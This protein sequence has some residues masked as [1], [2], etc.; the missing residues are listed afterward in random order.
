VPR[1]F[2]PGEAGSPLESLEMHTGDLPLSRVYTVI[3]GGGRGQRLY[4]LTRHRAKPAVPL[5]A[6]YR[7]IDIPLSNAINSGFRQIAVLTQF[8]SASLNAH[9]ATTYRFDIFGNGNVEVF[10]A[11]QTEEGTGWFEGTADAV[12]KHLRRLGAREMEHLLVLSG[13]HLY[14]MDYRDML[15]RHLESGADVT[16]SV[17]PVSRKECDGFGVLSADAEGRVHR[18][19][20]KPRSEEDLVPLIPPPEIRAAWKLGP[21]E[22]LASMGVYIFKI[23]TVREVLLRPEMI[24]FG[25]DIL[26]SLLSSHKVVAHFYRGYWRDIGTIGSFFDANIA[27]TDEEPPFRFFHPEAPIYTRLRFLPASKF[28]DATIKRSIVS[29]GCLVFGASLDRCVVGIR[30]RIQDGARLRD[31]IVMGN[32]FYEEDDVRTANA[33]RG[34]DAAGI[35]PGCVV[36]RAII[37]KNARLGA[38]CVLKGHP[39]RR[40]ED[41]DGWYVRDGV[42]IVPKDAHLKPGTVV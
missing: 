4:P 38:G 2:S 24:D 3:L 40:D 11:Q 13:D 30:S 26:P 8:N 28:V 9:I 18:F 34:L 21:D 1:L 16:V 39:E 10:A 37:D 14:R 7:L 25:K 32:D 23:D 41:G 27:L 5:G 36:E 22:F 29:D 31:V 20:E 42:V 6:K 33:A 19:K 15:E 17:I 35:G 12:R